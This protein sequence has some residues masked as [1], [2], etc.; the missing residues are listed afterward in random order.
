MFKGL[1]HVELE[2]QKRKNRV[3]AIFEETILK[4][5]QNG[6]KQILKIQRSLKSMPA[7]HH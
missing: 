7:T 6:E 1:M 3:E 4:I 5:L 2:F